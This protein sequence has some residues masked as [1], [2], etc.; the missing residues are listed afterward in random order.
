MLKSAI[1]ILGT[2]YVAWFMEQFELKAIYPFDATYAT[3]EAAG[4]PQLTET[5]H[6]TSDGAQ[7]VMWVST[8]KANRPT[9]LYF[10]GNSGTLKDRA[11]RFRQFTDRGYGLVAPAYRGSS[12]SDGKPDEALLL[13][14][15]RDRICFVWRKPRS[16]WGKPRRRSSDP[17]GIGRH[18]RRVGA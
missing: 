9:V 5:R 6:A 16:L 2:S 15:A 1:L 3:P 11:D 12:G 17:A 18:R 4:V 8:P 10:S 14:D 13:E 7:L